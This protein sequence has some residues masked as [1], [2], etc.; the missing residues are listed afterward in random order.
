MDNNSAG[1]AFF[2]NKKHNSAI[3]A[4]DTK[5]RRTPAFPK[6]TAG[7]GA[8]HAFFIAGHGAG[9]AFFINKNQRR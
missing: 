7:H 4:Q 9:H 1:H 3:T 6:Q 8:G 5:Q 2:I